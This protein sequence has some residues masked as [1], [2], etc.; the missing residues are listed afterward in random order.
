MKGRRAA[1]LA[2]RLA[3]A[4]VLLATSLGKLLDIRGFANVLRTYE[5]FPDGVLFALAL[6]IPLAELALAAWLLMGSALRVAAAVSV[7]LHFSYAFWSAVS[8][9]RGLKLSNCGCFGVF[10][11]RP[12]GWSTVGEDLVLAAGSLMLA[13]LARN[14]S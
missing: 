9:L 5:A 6:A 12:L 14:D 4:V 2:L 13:N 1:R 7:V 3:I 11:P 8:V 10:W